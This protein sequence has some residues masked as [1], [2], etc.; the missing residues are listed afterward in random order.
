MLDRFLASLE[1][2]VRDVLLAG[3]AAASGYLM[4]R[5]V[6]KTGVEFKALLVGALYAALRAAVAFAVT[7]LRK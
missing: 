5:E 6:P 2:S 7:L 3:V 1:A 4:A